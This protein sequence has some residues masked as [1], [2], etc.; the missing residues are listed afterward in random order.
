MNV[1]VKH[2]CMIMN[3]N[4]KIRIGIIPLFSQ[5]QFRKRESSRSSVCRECQ[6]S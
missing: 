5:T 2:V 6:E 1:S 3:I 4:V